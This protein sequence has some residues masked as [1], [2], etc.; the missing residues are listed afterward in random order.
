ML[1]CRLA[2][3]TIALSMSC[4]IATTKKKKRQVVL[5]KGLP[6]KKRNRGRQQ[7]QSTDADGDVGHAPAAMQTD[8]LKGKVRET[9][10]ETYL[11]RAMRW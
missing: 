11:K 4:G 8:P 7:T 2:C 6:A 10:S 3:Q 1:V 9:I 5:Q